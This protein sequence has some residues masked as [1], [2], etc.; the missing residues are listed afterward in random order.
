MTENPVER[1]PSIWVRIAIALTAA[2]GAMAWLGSMEWYQ[3]HLVT[4]FDA[5]FAGAHALLHG[6]DP[7]R[8]YYRPISYP[9]PAMLV[10]MPLSIGPIELARLLFVGVSSGLLGWSLSR[11][12]DARLFVF[13]SGAWFVAVEDAQWSPLILA[14]ATMPALA[15]VLPA[16]PNIGLAVAAGTMPRS[17]KTV[18]VLALILPALSFIV[19]PSW[20][21]AWRSDVRHYDVFTPLV[22]RPYG[23]L[24]L[25]AAARWRRP[26]ARLLLTLALVPLNP[27]FYEA[28]LVFC[29]PKRLVE[30]AALAAL[31]WFVPVVGRPMVTDYA[32]YA[33]MNAPAFARGTLICAYLPALLIILLRP[34]EGEVP[35][36][37][38]RM[39]ARAP[40]WLRGSAES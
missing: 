9:L 16:K 24:L 35:A 37:L 33:S 2:A 5:V 15:W 1:T 26:E 39:L 10:A 6:A 14:A 8:S 17:I 18:C 28:V 25:L 12:P 36:W 32:T 38:E 31:S 23:A 20:V 19:A 13:A 3:P 21:G 7:F 34:N 22:T 29:V 27:A 30:G 11:K 40:R 4:D